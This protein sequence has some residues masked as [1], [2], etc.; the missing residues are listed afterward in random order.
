MLSIII[1]LSAIFC[2]K[3]FSFAKNEIANASHIEILNEKQILINTTSG[4]LRA[5]NNSLIKKGTNEYIGDYIYSP[6]NSNG[7]NMIMSF[8]FENNTLEDN[9][10]LCIWVYIPSVLVQDL[11]I[12]ISNESSQ[13]IWKF[14]GVEISEHQTGNLSLID[15]IEEF[16]GSLSQGW[17]LLSLSKNDSTSKTGT[18]LNYFSSLK[19]DYGMSVLGE[20]NDDEEFSIC[21]PFIA[22]KISE[23]SSII[24]SQSYIIYAEK[25]I[26]IKEN[27]TMYIGEKL[28]I[29]SI[30]NVF[31]YVVIGK[32]NIL[33]NQSG[34]VWNATLT[35]P[36]GTRQSLTFDKKI[37]ITLE[38]N[39]YYLLDITLTNI[40]QDYL[41]IVSRSVNIKVEKFVFGFFNKSDFNIA[42]GKTSV[43]DFYLS[44]DFE[45]E[46]NQIK[47]K[48]SDDNILKLEYELI[49]NKIRIYVG[50]Q[51]L[52]SSTLTLSISGKQK[53]LTETK[54]YS[55]TININV[56]NEKS[57]SNNTILFVVFGVMITG[58]VVYIIISFVKSRRFGVK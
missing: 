22:D 20:D 28:T 45:F 32:Q 10:M 19:I 55:E 25:D 9:Q 27:T 15:L 23:K 11:S 35:L 54:E 37:D 1:F 21:Y 41:P 31:V 40:E 39:G 57:E 51:N 36:S 26:F 52:G 6:I 43:I 42:V 14:D 34:Y 12:T 58:I 18:E 49:D 50:A 16:N 47:I 13:I 17:K 30:K 8:S 56:L 33:D 29:N 48:A 4:I 3:Y 7:N 44:K 24:D 53:N 2:C 5:Q 46:D 38:T